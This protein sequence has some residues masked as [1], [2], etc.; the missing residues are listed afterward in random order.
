VSFATGVEGIDLAG[1][2]VRLAPRWSLSEFQVILLNTTLLRDMLGL[3]HDSLDLHVER[4][5]YTLRTLPRAAPGRHPAFVFAHIL[6]PH[7]PFVLR[8]PGLPDSVGAYGSQVLYLSML[9]DG[10][11]RRILVESPRPPVIL[12]QADHGLRGSM[13]WGDSAR[14]QLL[15][16]HA[17]L[18]AA[19]LPPSGRQVESPIQ[20]YDSISS[21]NTFRVVL[22]TYFDTTMSLLPDRSYYSSLDRP[23][24][25]YDV[26]RPESYPVQG[27]PD[28][29]SQ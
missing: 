23:Y 12:I 28:R 10:V 19:Y 22:S 6:C 18:Y 15:E 9:L 4:V 17:I 1:A 16:R 8:A 5:S 20:L 29:R 13:V 24:Q 11:V 3:M 21:V 26:A 2:D 14:N 27:E 25:F 7:R